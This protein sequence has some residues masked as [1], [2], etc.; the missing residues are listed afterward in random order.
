MA[1]LFVIAGPNG[2][3]KSTN[4]KIL[5]SEEG[6]T[7]FDYDLELYSLW[8]RFSYDPA[9]E[10]GVRESVAENFLS[11]KQKALINKTSFAFETNY[12]HLSSFETVQQFKK[13]GHETILIFIALPNVEAA[14][15]R[16][17]TRVSKGGHSVS[18]ATIRERFE[19]GLAQ[20]DD[21]FMEFDVVYLYRSE[22]N[23]NSL[24]Y[25]LLPNLGKAASTDKKLDA[26][27]LK[28]LPK[29]ERFVHSSS[30]TIN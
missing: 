26:N 22:E 7:A 12:H 10:E 13:S 27:I 17:K 11:V 3:G 9:V 4:N 21:T 29:I 1:S 5:L 18:V 24:V 20:L 16:V 19:R 25:T 6:I 23:E 30:S 14:I 2:A 15:E 8:S 28:Y